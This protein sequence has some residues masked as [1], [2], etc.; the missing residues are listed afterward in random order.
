MFWNI[1]IYNHKIA[2]HEDSNVSNTGVVDQRPFKYMDGVIS[3]LFL[4]CIELH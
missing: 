1:D 4:Y 2:Q 3:Y